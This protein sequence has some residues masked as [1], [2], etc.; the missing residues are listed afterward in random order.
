M[1]EIPVR[2]TSG[3]ERP[4][5]VM[6]AVTPYLF[7]YAGYREYGDTAQAVLREA[8]AWEVDLQSTRSGADQHQE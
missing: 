6:E 8:L 3:E 2:L 1:V 4:G 5:E 7:V